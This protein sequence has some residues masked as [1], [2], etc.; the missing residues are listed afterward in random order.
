MHITLFMNFL[1]T[2]RISLGRVAENIMT[3]FSCGVILKTSCTSRR[4]SGEGRDIHSMATLCPGHG[5]PSCSSILSHSSR[6]KCLMFL[7]FRLRSRHSA[8]I[9]PGVPTTI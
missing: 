6:M 5:S 8:R 4:M 7:R 3:C 1:Q 2:G 9:R